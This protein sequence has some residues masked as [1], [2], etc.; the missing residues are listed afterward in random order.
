MRFKEA[1]SKRALLEFG[2]LGKLINR[3]K[4][5]FQTYQ[6]GKYICWTMIQMV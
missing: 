4:L 1:L 2:S 5:I 6:T 3:E